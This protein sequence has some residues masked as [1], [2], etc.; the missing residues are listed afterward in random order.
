LREH[1]EQLAFLRMEVVLRGPLSRELD[2]MRAFVRTVTEARGS[3][4]A[5][6][7]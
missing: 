5:A 7:G 4:A 2:E 3:F 1:K 6:L